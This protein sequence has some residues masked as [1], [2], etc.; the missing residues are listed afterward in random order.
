MNIKI[1]IK[2]VLRLTLRYIKEYSSTGVWELTFQEI[3]YFVPWVLWGLL[4]NNGTCGVPK[5]RRKYEYL[6]DFF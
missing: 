2:G 3:V 5:L 4:V 6:I 1:K